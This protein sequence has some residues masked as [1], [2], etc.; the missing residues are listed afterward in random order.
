M[1]KVIK[2]TAKPGIYDS[3]DIH[4]YHADGRV[5][6]SSGLKE[7]KKSSRHFAYFLLNPKPTTLT[8]DFGNAFEIA[9]VDAVAGT[10]QFDKD[11]SVIDYNNRPDPTKTM[12]ANVNK[13][14]KEEIMQ[15]GK[16][17][18][19]AT[20]EKESLE[21]CKRMVDSAMAEPLIRELLSIVD[22]Q[23]SFIWRDPDCGVMCKTRPD[24]GIRNKKIILDI[25]TTRD[26]SPE[27]FPKQSA[28]YDY[29][30][31]AIMQIEGALQS[32]YLEKVDEYFWL[33]CEKEPPYNA[34]LYRL[35]DEDR[36]MLYDNYKFYLERCAK[37]L[38]ALE[39][40]PNM[41]EAVNG[42]SENADNR[43]GVLDLEIP[44]FYKR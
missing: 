34:V 37:V 38:K 14:W 24:I 36:G 29:P 15:S 4:D 35:Q 8:L 33:A 12:A 3:I 20:G 10:K 40:N 42:Y 39:E 31:Q 11:V 16:Y 23:K 2:E 13:E 7:A 18:I 6:S 17:I 22:Y 27:Q 44:L 25:K 43:F 9:L 28:N 41:Y 32:G 26:A 19:P 5:V 1:K 21:A 30:L